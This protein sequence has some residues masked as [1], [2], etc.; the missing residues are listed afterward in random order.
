MYYKKETV[1]VNIAQEKMERMWGKDYKIVD[2]N[3]A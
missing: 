1:P 3:G 2:W